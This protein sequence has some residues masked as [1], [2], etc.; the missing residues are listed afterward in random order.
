MPEVVLLTAVDVGAN[1]EPQKKQLS[2][3]SCCYFERHITLII[4]YKYIL[5][6]ASSPVSCLTKLVGRLLIVVFKRAFLRYGRQ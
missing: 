6:A 5:P 2:G 1:T 3:T 4:C